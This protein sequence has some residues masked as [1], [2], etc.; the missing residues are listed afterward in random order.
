MTAPRLLEHVVCLGCGCS[1]DDIALRIDGD[2]IVEARNA[3]PLGVRWFGDGR[4]PGKVVVRGNP[5]ER[6]AAVTRIAELLSG[7]RPALVYLAPD[8]SIESQ[9]AAVAL[10]DRTGAR[11][12]SVTSD[13]VAAGIIAGQRRGRATCTLGEIRN[14]ADL[15]VF[16]G[17]DPDVRYPRY[18]SRY[19]LEP[20]G[21]QVP[22][23]RADRTVIAVDVANSRG[24]AAAAERVVLNGA[25]ESAA[26]GIM[27]AVVQGRTLTG[28]SGGLAAAAD[29]ARRMM[30]A[31]YVVIVADAEPGEPGPSD[32]QRAEGLT[33]LALALNGPTRC[34]LSSLR[35]GGNR[36]GADAV[37]TWQTG[38]PFAVDFSFGVPRYRPEEP[39]SQLAGVVGAALI[40]GSAGGVPDA[41]RTALARIPVAVVG[42]RASESPIAAEVAID[43]GVA[44][45]HEAGTGYRMDDVPLPLTEALAGPPSAAALLR[46]VAAA[47]ATKETR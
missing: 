15:L 23:G 8:I 3:C 21:L 47:L 31:R 43:T 33:G 30:Q 9:R 2:R 17:V 11:L 10:A 18:L 12:D 40:V 7:D 26:I 6:A 39:A 41:V 14:R 13:T 5:A 44:G 45:I 46:D 35:A 4:V 37:C 24:P 22:K 28:L 27:R 32:P 29:L 34:S 36:S 20:A 38:F 16:W 42:P 19:A 25:E 1:C